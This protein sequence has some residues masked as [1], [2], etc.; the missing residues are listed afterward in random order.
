MSRAGHSE[1]REDTFT[2]V[3]MVDAVEF[4]AGKKKIGKKFFKKLK[5]ILRKNKKTKKNYKTS[6]HG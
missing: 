6:F 4:V 3:L 5:K 1:L 2:D